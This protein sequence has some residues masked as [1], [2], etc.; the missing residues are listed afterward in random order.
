MY[1]IRKIFR[2]EAAHRLLHSFSQECNNLHGH[3]YLIEIFLRSEKIGDNY[4]IIDFKELKLTIDKIINRYDHALLI[5]DEDRE[6]LLCAEKLNTKYKTISGETTCENLARELFY[7]IV[8][9]NLKEGI[10]IPISL[11]RIHETSTGYAE[12][13]V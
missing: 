10:N 3:S 6:L 4:M 11:I 1:Q 2:F 5:S 8:T 12:Y 13:E 9:D 7:E